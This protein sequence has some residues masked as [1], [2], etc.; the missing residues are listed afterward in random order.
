LHR[1]LTLLS[2]RRRALVRAL[3]VHGATLFILFP[4]IFGIGLLLLSRVVGDLQE[5]LRFDPAWEWLFWLLTLSAA[6]M[7]CRRPSGR[8]GTSPL[9]CLPMGALA[10]W[11]DG[12]LAAVSRLLPLGLLLAVIVPTLGGG[13]R[14]LAVLGL[15]LL[16]PAALAWQKPGGGGAGSRPSAM[17]SQVVTLLPK[18]LRGLARR[19]LL[20]VMRGAVPSR[21]VY[22]ALGAVALLGVV[23]AALSGNIRY[24]LVATALSA[25][26]L[27][28]QVAALLA[29]QWRSMWLEFD[30][31]VSVRDL[32][33]AK[34]AT[35]G[36]LGAVSGCLAGLIWL[37]VSPLQAILFPALGIAVGVVVGAAIM[38][39][40]GQPLLHGVVSL[41]LAV[42]VAV[43]G[44]IQPLLLLLVIL[45][46][47]YLETLA[48]PRLT[49]RLQE[50]AVAT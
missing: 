36:L 29:A 15:L 17:L 33:R 48:L 38:E 43:M 26:A 13:I 25:W 19:D 4:F 35:A 28:A 47:N 9:A 31:G 10:L 7:L 6:V 20:L 11:L 1:A 8:H 24:G 2:L 16:V 41:L 30:A 45:P 5:Q 49:R 21:G 39:G 23:A 40:D 32:W 27:S 50:I 44:V 37:Y 34:V 42:L 46:F 3:R 18:S 12:Y 22:L 14:W